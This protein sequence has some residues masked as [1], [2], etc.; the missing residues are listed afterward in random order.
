MS[1]NLRDHIPHLS[2]GYLTLSGVGFG[3]HGVGGGG[4][5]GTNTGG[6]G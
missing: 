5:G 2:H 6:G 4:G 3:G 1:Q